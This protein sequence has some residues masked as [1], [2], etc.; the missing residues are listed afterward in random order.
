MQS[1]EQWFGRECLRQPTHQS[2]C[3]NWAA[4]LWRKADKSGGELACWNWT[5]SFRDS[6]GTHRYGKHHDVNGRATRAHKQAYELVHGPVPDGTFVMHT[7]D[8]PACINPSH[9][10][11]GTP[12]QNARDMI[13]KDR[14]AWSRTHCANGHARAEHTAT[15]RNGRRVCRVCNAEHQRRWREGNGAETWKECQ[16]RAAKRAWERQ[17]AAKAA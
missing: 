11:A 12:F 10:I 15:R 7:C 1:A 17:K 8:N 13:E 4:D 16:R 14:M 3:P 2:S 6:R 9:L 5:A